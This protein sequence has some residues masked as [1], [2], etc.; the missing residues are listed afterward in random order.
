MMDVLLAKE[1]NIASD[2]VFLLVPFVS[3]TLNNFRLINYCLNLFVVC[4]LK[5]NY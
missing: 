4:A 1:L 3:I 2:E 5:V